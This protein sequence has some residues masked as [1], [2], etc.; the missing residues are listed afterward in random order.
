MISMSGEIPLVFAP[1]GK[2]MAY[3]SGGS[4]D[5]MP[6]VTIVLREVATGALKW[7]AKTEGFIAVHACL[8]FSPDGKS[9]AWTTSSQAGDGVVQLFSSE[10]GKEQGR[11][12]DSKRH[13]YLAAFSPDG[14]TVAT[15]NTDPIRRHPQGHG[16][17]VGVGVEKATITLWD[18]AT[19]KQ[20][21]VLTCPERAI[22]SLA[23]SPDGKMLAS[24]EMLSI[25]VWDTDKAKVKWRFRPGPLGGGIGRS[26]AFTARTDTLVVCTAAPFSIVLFDLKTGR[27]KWT[28]RASKRDMLISATGLSLSGRIAAS[29]YPP[30]SKVRLWD[31]HTGRELT[32]LPG[33]GG[34]TRY[35]GDMVFDTEKPLTFSPDE[36]YLA[37][38]SRGDGTVSLWNIEEFAPQAP[39]EPQPHAPP[40]R[41]TH[42][43]PKTEPEFRTWTSDDG[44]FTVE[45]KLVK[46]SGDVITLKRKTGEEIDVPIEKLSKKDQEFIR[47]R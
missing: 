29:V 22:G 32:T 16:A 19:R 39:S 14:K 1:D 11:L 41:R 33:P 10:T 21:A 23:F 45:A 18:V 17:G 3:P 47:G 7:T 2:T 38:A 40:E 13:F 43:R 34:K 42:Q 37:G 9:L 26:I 25:T 15:A 8:M 35:P 4:P 28:S 24:S 27:P 6:Q 36:K 44:Q 30:G 46:T 12:V 31:T 5:Q 20:R